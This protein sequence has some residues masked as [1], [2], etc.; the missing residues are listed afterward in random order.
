MKKEKTIFIIQ[1]IELGLSFL[2]CGYSLIMC[3]AMGT[4]EEVGSYILEVSYLFLHLIA[5]AMIFY[6]SLRAVKFGSFFIRN[7]M[8]DS[9]GY[10]S[11]PKKVISLVLSILFLGLGIYS[12]LQ[13]SGLSL[14]LSGVI[15]FVVWH[16]LMNG[17]ILLSMISLSFYLYSFVPYELRDNRRHSD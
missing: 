7:V 13:I 15:S 3:F 17:F 12:I 11:K 6:L 10:I 4:N 2:L 1:A 8:F 14:P 16:D 5:V 9:Q